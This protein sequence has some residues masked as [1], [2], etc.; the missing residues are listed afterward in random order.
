MTDTFR[1]ALPPEL[2]DLPQIKDRLTFLYLEKCRI[3]REDSA[4]KAENKDGYVLIPAGMYLVLILGPGVALTHRAAELLGHAGT[5]IVWTGDTAI[6][7]YGYGKSL[8]ENSRLLINQARIVSYP[9][10][11]IEAV[12]K[13]Y[14]LRY[15]DE[16]LT[17]L[18]LQ[19]LRGKEGARMRKTYAE[20]AKKYGVE[21]T[22]RTY[23]V[24]DFKSGTPINRALSVAN[25]CLYGLCYSVI[26]GMGL[27]P[28]LGLIHVGHQLSLVYDLAD[29]YKA[30][31]T[32]PLCFELVSVSDYEIESRVRKEIRTSFWSSKLIERMVKD[33]LYIFQ[34]GVTDEESYSEALSLWD[35]MRGSVEA[36]IQ[37]H[38]RVESGDDN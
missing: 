24:D 32:I 23:R 20:N 16:D 1:G 37:Y 27:S 19:Q 35:G 12:K 2:H 17:S 11:H 22:G 30:E 14:G 38:P 34:E 10:L 7:F 33:L 28:G 18:T 6:K 31:L 9:K 15:P 29:L 5:A 21:W 8:A 36:G 4:L 26:S 25:T 3:S 13:L